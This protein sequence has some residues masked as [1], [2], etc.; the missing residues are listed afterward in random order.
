MHLFIYPE[1]D[2]TIYNDYTKQNTGNDEILEIQNSHVS[3]S[4]YSDSFYSRALVQFNIDWMSQSISDGTIG[5]EKFYLNL[6]LAYASEIINDPVYLYIYP[7]SQ[8]WVEGYGKRFDSPIRTDG[9]SWIYRDGEVTSS[10][11]QSGSDYISS[12]AY[13]ITASLFDDQNTFQEDGNYIYEISDVRADVTNIVRGWLSGSVTN[14][15]FII[16]RSNSEETDIKDRGK[17]CFYSMNSHTINT[18]SLEVVWD[19]SSYSTGSSTEVQLEDA[20]VYVKNLKDTYNNRSISRIRIGSREAYPT[21]SF[22]SSNPYS[23]SKHLPSSSFYS[24][25]DV[26]SN[27]TIIPFGDYSK[28]SCDSNG[29]YFNLRMDSFYPERKYKVEIK[30]ISSSL[31]EIY[32]DNYT[33][34]VVR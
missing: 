19:D 1:K 11:A 6:K 14:N 12:S 32:D 18:P 24:I 29:N 17:L 9:V 31:E 23:L 2:S 28:L 30:I 33:F 20:F 4:L 27:E 8:S 15:G 25:V 3:M 7:I 21:R 26:A 10:W 34:K 16:K 22:A 13:E 5:T